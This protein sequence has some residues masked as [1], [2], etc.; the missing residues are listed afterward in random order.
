MKINRILIPPKYKLFYHELKSM[1]FNLLDIGCGDHSPTLTKYWFPK[2]RYYGLDKQIYNNSPDDLEVMEIFYKID[3]ERD[4]LKEIPD[5]F[6]NVIILSHVLE[7]LSNGL[8]VLETLSHKLQQQGKIYVEVPS[9]RSLALPSA[10]GTL[11][12]CDDPTHIRFYGIVEIVNTLL[13]NGVKI[14]KARRRRN[15][16]R[17]LITPLIIPFH[18]GFRLKHGEWSGRGLWDLLGFADYV[19]GE[20]RT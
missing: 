20:K 1:S 9:I 2:C 3:L 19:Y 8:E 14:I 15:W 6:F 17:I 4:N 18:L 11:N 12:F 16:P 13:A 7:H 5:S 10:R